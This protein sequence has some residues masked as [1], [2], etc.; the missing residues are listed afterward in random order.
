MPILDEMVERRARDVR[1]L[2]VTNRA[3]PRAGSEEGSS[4]AETA[5]A[6]LREE[7]GL[8]AEEADLD[9]Y[10]CISRA[11]NH[12]V[13]HDNGDR[14]HYFGIWFELRRWRGDPVPDG[15]EMTEVGWFDPLELPDPL[16]GST[17]MGLDLR[18]AWHGTGR[19][20]AR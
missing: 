19:F 16:L 6:E 2:I 5:L 12:V 3:A 4:F 7:V 8:E 10:A 9:G 20:Q 15:E 14:M 13:H 17:R 11:E 1:I 18:E